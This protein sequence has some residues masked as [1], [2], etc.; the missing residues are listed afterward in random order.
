MSPKT[1]R[2]FS[3][4]AGAL[5]V[6][7][8]CAGVACTSPEAPQGSARRQVVEVR[9]SSG[10]SGGML[11]ALA[12]ADPAATHIMTVT[13]RLRELREDR[14][15]AGILLKI[16][17][18]RLSRADLQEVTA[19]LGE[20]R[21]T[22][23]Q[24]I[25]YGLGPTN[26]SY[27][28]ACAADRIVVAPTSVVDLTGLT[29]G[30]MFYKDL[31]D[32]AGVRADFVRAGEYKS[33]VEPYTRTGMSDE[34]REML[35]RLLD[36]FYA[37]MTAAIAVERGFSIQ[38]VEDIIDGGPY[39]A[40]E[41]LEAGL[42]DSLAYVDELDAYVDDVVGEDVDL[43]GRE[44]V[45]GATGMSALVRMVRE[46]AASD[47]VKQS[48]NDKIALIHM[49][50]IITAGAPGGLGAS[51]VVTASAVGTAI[52]HAA[53]DDTVKAI[54]LRINSPGGS[55]LASDLIWRAVVQASKDKP[56]VA[57]M[58][59]V[60][61]SGGYY[62]AMAA[63]RV[64]ADPG[65]VT[66]SV[67]VFGGKFDFGGLYGKIG[68][69]R[70]VIT[71]G[72]NATIYADTGGFTDSE[73]ERVQSLINETYRDFVQKAAD[74]R[75]MDFEAMEALAR[76]QVWTGA[77]AFE[78]GMIDQLGGL[79]RAFEVAKV[80]AGYPEDRQFEL[81]ELPSQPTF[82]DMFEEDEWSLAR[83]APGNA[84]LVGIEGG[85]AAFRALA[86]ERTFALM[87][88]ELSFE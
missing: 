87:P 19:A 52:R 32:K 37:Q 18:A 44:A 88:F 50:G 34:H 54:V 41:A 35:T 28:L 67:G 16:D 12:G 33:A 63:D 29:A 1:S 55:A 86:R 49:D 72:R 15:V 8:A 36:D 85:V 22:G 78:N 39:T 5:I 31:M 42:V 59:S 27:T 83:W 40:H 62:V 68:I 14:Q 11:T 17:S 26:G 57:S 23:K 21:K 47:A 84:L 56:V 60:A 58:G 70:E 80:Q 81:L 4:A 45:S 9:L 20:F 13:G 77:E 38:E 3:D 64:L 61:A 25:A 79:R 71:R 65:T 10:A 76:G 24:V 6:L 66:G 30:V 69:T 7:V 51:G 53:E 82:W 43:V 74:G 2:R 48:P 73:R 75:D 46:A